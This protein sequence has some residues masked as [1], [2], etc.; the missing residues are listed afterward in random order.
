MMLTM[1][2]YL[3]AGETVISNLLIENYYKIGMTE[4]EFMFWL[5]LYKKQQ[6]GDFF[7]DLLEIGQVMGKSAERT[8]QLLNEL[9]S[10]NL[11]ALET[12]QNSSGQMTD[13]YDLL[14][15]FKRISDQQ[16]SEMQKNIL[17]QSENQIKEMYQSFEKE[18]G[19]PLSPIELEM[20]GQWLDEDHY[21]PEI[22][23]LALREAVLNQAYS[24]KY[25]DRIL[26]SWERK[27]L[28]TKEQVAEDRKRH[29]QL[30]RQKELD[31]EETSQQPIPKVP[32]YNWLHPEDE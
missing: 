30:M 29:K 27:N 20:I 6:R 11:I 21:K 4:E 2:E 19:R 16:V 1:E 32:L 24:L 17:Q 12:K 14:P 31:K 23:Q 10:K 18:F 13:A 5:Q 22:I 8:Y 7:P 26:L 25:I 9:V 28:T 15:I 3:Q